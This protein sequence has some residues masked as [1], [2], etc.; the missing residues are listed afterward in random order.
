MSQLQCV[1]CKFP[2]PVSEEDPDSSL[3]DIFEHVHRKH[4]DALKK[5]VELVTLVGEND[6]AGPEVPC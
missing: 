2:V 3:S 5:P 6:A 1:V 4:P